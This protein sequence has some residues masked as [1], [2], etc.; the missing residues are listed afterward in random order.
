MCEILKCAKRQQ[1]CAR[2]GLRLLY[3]ANVIGQAHV[4]VY[5]DAAIMM[6]MMMTAKGALGLR[7][8]RDPWRCLC[9][10]VCVCVQLKSFAI[11]LAANNAD[12]H[13]R[14]PSHPYIY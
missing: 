2:C 3:T 14:F 5:T 12:R 13:G 4:V 1:L 9:V 11:R 6:M 8:M 10:C 7:L